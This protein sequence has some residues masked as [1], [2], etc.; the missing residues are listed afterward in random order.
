MLV[1]K[2]RFASV[3]LRSISNLSSYGTND[4][5]QKTNLSK[6]SGQL[7]KWLYLLSLPDI[8]ILRWNYGSL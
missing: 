5:A 2:T 3:K 8:L 1:V 6:S 4:C 7:S